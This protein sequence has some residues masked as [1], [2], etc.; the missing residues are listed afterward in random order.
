MY[1]YMC[2]AMVWYCDVCVWVWW[3]ATLETHILWMCASKVCYCDVCACIMR[4]YIHMQYSY[5]KMCIHDIHTH[6]EYFTQCLSTQDLTPS[7]VTGSAS[8]TVHISRVS[9]RQSETKS[10]WLQMPRYNMHTKNS[11]C[12]HTIFIHI[13]YFTP[14]LSTQDL[15]PSC[16]T[17]GA[18]K[19]V[20]ISRVS[21]RD[22]VPLAANAEILPSLLA[23][24][25]GVCSLEEADSLIQTVSNHVTVSADACSDQHENTSAGSASS[26][27]EHEKTSDVTVSADACSKQH[28]NTSAGSALCSEH[29]STSEGLHHASARNRDDANGEDAEVRQTYACTESCFLDACVLSQLRCLATAAVCAHMS[30]PSCADMCVRHGIVDTLL[31]ISSSCV[32]AD[33]HDQDFD[34]G[35]DQEKMHVALL[36][37]MHYLCEHHGDD[38]DIHVRSEH[39]PNLH[40]VGGAQSNSNGVSAGAEAAGGAQ[41]QEA[42]R[43]ENDARLREQQRNA[44]AQ[45]LTA[46]GYGLPLCR[47]ALQVCVVCFCHAHTSTFALM[48]PYRFG[49]C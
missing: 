5:F 2:T 14:C 30:D 18:T 17:G 29:E 42:S 3:S 40:S 43:R 11:V 41:A 45:D 12:A 33:L 4:M 44:R 25:R 28:E 32:S 31:S 1:V 39:E 6:T 9:L 15:T 48:T 27:T 34:E 8:K 47:V 16:G 7:C 13:Q 37:R 26:C 49:S 24:L 10:P 23:A 36:N 38:H 22:E 21:I 35:I 20:H 46:L 19:T